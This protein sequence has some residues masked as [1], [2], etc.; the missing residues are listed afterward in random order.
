MPSKEFP[1]HD[2]E[3]VEISVIKIDTGQPEFAYD[4]DSEMSL[5][6]SLIFLED[7]EGK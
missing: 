3:E 7:E 5:Y 6:R 2:F 4:L 1:L